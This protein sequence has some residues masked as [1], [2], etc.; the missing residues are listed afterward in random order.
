ML[1]VAGLTVLVGLAMAAARPPASAAGSASIT[2]YRGLG[3]WVDMYD[4]SAWNDPAAAVKDMAAHGVR[5]LYIETANYHNPATTPMFKPAAM[6]VFITGVSRAQDA[7]S[8]PGT[9]RASRILP[10]TRTRTTSAA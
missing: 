8:W 7:G 3:T 1:L 10:R 6:A 4:P 2:A 5:T 9:C